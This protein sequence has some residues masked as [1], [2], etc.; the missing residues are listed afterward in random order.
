M[1]RITPAAKNAT[2]RNKA[3][4]AIP[5]SAERVRKHRAKMRRAGM[6]LL[7]IWVPDPDQPG[8]AEECRRQSLLVRDDPLEK[9]ILE[10]IAAIADLRG[11]K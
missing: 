8:F 11:W 9:Q 1:A 6:K 5:R 10:E 3:R 7:Q 4:N 2:S